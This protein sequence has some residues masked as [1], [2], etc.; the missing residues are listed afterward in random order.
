MF[1][2]KLCF[3]SNLVSLC[4]FQLIQ[5]IF[6][7]IEIFLKFFNKPLS[8]SIDRNYVSINRNSWIRF[9]KNSDLTCSNHFFKTFQNF[10]LSLRLGKA[11]LR[12]FFCRFPSNFL[13]GFSLPKPVCLFYPSFCIIFTFSCI[14]LMVFG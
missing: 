8:V 10:F 1:F 3:S 2:Q 7:L 6:R 13:Q 14:N 11:P 12:F 4:Q 5:S 9:F